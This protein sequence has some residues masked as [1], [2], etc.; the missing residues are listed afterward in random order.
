MCFDRKVSYL[1]LFSCLILLAG[2]C[3]IWF[4]F[5]SPATDAR[6]LIV[7]TEYSGAN[8][9][10]VER[11]ITIP[12]EDA[13]GDSTGV[14][15]LSSSSEFGKSRI[16]VF[17][18]RDAD[19]NTLYADV[20]E[21][22]ELARADF[23]RAVQKTRVARGDATNRPVFIVS[24]ESK[25]IGRR[26][27]GEYID[28]S[29]KTRYE[30][31][32][33]TGEVETGG[34]AIED[35]MVEVDPKRSAEYGIDP[36]C[37]SEA[38]RKG[39]ARFPIGL[40]ESG[41]RATPLF[42]D[43]DLRDLDDFKRIPIPTASGAPIRLSAVADVSRSYRFTEQ[44]SRI[45]GDERV[46]L[47]VHSGSTANVLALCDELASVTSGITKEGL[48]A[49]VIYSKGDEIREG[50]D[51]I[52]ISMAISIA[53]LFAFIGLFMPDARSR[54]I[55]SLSI[56]LSI[57]LGLAAISAFRVPVDASIVSGLTIG[58]GLIID[59]YLIIY[60]YIKKNRDASI[61][62]IA[63]P[64][65]SGTL[66]TLIVFL[67]LLS[68][69]SLNAGIQS[70][71]LS[72]CGMLVISQFLTFTF[73]PLP[74]KLAV[75][76]E[77]ARKP[78]IP[79]ALVARPFF[80]LTELSLRYRKPLRLAYALIILSV[81][82]L[83]LL[84]PKEF[85]PIDED[86]IIFARAEFPSGTT[87]SEVDSR[88]LPYL[89]E[90]RKVPAVRRVESNA[91][92]GAAEISVTFDNDAVESSALQE[93]L[94]QITARSTHARFFFGL[95]QNTASYKIRLTL[96]GSDHAALRERVRAIGET[97]SREDWVTG[98]VYNFKDNPPARA[99]VPDLAKLAAFGLYP[100]RVASNLRWN[101]QGPVAIKW[102]EKQR[103]RDVRV[104]SPPED[105]SLEGLASI[106]L[107]V[108]GS[109]PIPLSVVGQFRECSEPERLYRDNR[110]N[111]VNFTLLTKRLALDTI[112][113]RLK[114]VLATIELPPGYGLFP[115]SSLGD[116]L[117]EYRLMFL[118][119]A[120]ACFLI[121]ALLAIENESATLPILIIS[122]I[123][124]SAFFPLIFL[125]AL[126]KPITIAS[127][128]GM[129]ILSGT[130]VN[131]YI[132]I[133]DSLASSQGEGS[134][135]DR[136]KTALNDRFNPLFL[137]C[138]TSVIASLPILFSA[139]PFS[140]FPS[141]LAIIITLGILG[142]FVGSFLFLPA[143]VDP[144]IPADPE[145]QPK[146]DGAMTAEALSV[147]PRGA[148]RQKHA[149]PCI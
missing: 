73:I 104:S 71:S 91:R 7:T 37:V 30:R 126:G 96:T 54:A 21:R 74:L 72:I 61:A 79:F 63:L 70:I 59:N 107:A 52:L 90:F 84:E 99:F 135:P 31:V 80:A 118:V 143:I 146:G 139:R 102:I 33:G 76:R 50:I 100:D 56:P 144:F 20:T 133:T 103:E 120:F 15:K 38:L 101:V 43:G 124:F 40:V 113:A 6:A 53:S 27:L 86:G 130:S 87:I 111:S 145:T 121:Y 109:S 88:I 119:F 85:T 49:R 128:I 36:L 2:L 24:F 9:R 3:F 60:D 125:V 12:I 132:L 131:N 65:L 45:D 78:T 19:M 46:I 47:Y 67:P 69:K 148:F 41:D 122:A 57:F 29:V 8:A 89:R 141:A 42:F 62:P 117:R 66:T 114:A 39:Y 97:F 22:V 147:S 115:D 23:P 55:L 25:S 137:S 123:P 26:E 13:L 138:G 93:R 95:D 10:E 48:D 17:A 11:V 92:R 4:R 127:I 18:K 83:L 81:P 136:V 35:I 110:Q 1:L 142:S 140:D 134:F 68:L 149:E 58:S 51:K 75:E 82:A 94:E 98:V 28:D 5:G 129:I 116:S 44:R 106:P 64:L 105:R 32:R 112:N 108:S 16:T 77:T 14:L 34:R